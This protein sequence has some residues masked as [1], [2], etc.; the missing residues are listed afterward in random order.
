MRAW[1]RTVLAIRDTPEAQARGLAIGFFFGVSPLWGLQILLA[2]GAAQLL[3]GNKVLAAAMTAVSNPLTSVPLY[4]ACLLL[5]RTLLG[6]PGQPAVDLAALSSAEDLLR[7]GPL[8]LLHLFAGT[9]LVGAAGAAILYLVAGR[10]PNALA[11]RGRE[12][13]PPPAM[14]KVQEIRVG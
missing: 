8:F 14:A 9:T 7:Q 1:L 10:L 6:G 5:G 2:A 12:A 3:R 11:R 13:P 4:G